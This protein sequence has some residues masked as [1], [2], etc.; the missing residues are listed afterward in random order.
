MFYGLY[1]QPVV[2]PESLYP[3]PLSHIE[4]GKVAPASPGAEEEKTTKSEGKIET[5]KNPYFLLYCSSCDP[6]RSWNKTEK[7]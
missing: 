3:T 4:V 7:K 1:N 6:V 5:N 2:A